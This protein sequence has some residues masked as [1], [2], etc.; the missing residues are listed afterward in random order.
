[1]PT[2]SSLYLWI[3]AMEEYVTAG[4]PVPLAVRSGVGGAPVC[5]PLPDPPEENCRSPMVGADLGCH[6]HSVPCPGS[7]SL[8]EVAES[9]GRHGS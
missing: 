2:P 3:A 9:L 4:H 6:W 5:S 8:V 1:M 7:F